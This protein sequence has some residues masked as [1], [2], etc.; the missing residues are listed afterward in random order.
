[1][2]QS[3]MLI[4]ALLKRDVRERT[5][6]IAQCAR[7]QARKRLEDNEDPE[8]AKKLA[9]NSR[10]NG[11][12]KENR[13][14]LKELAK[15]GDAEAVEKYQGLKEKENAR[16]KVSYKKKKMQSCDIDEV[17]SFSTSGL[18]VL[19]YAKRFTCSACGVA[20]SGQCNNVVGRLT[21]L[22]CTWIS[23]DSVDQK[24]VVEEAKELLESEVM[25]TEARGKSYCD[26]LRKTC[27]ENF[28]KLEQAFG[29]PPKRSEP[30]Q[31]PVV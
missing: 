26:L 19:S 11:Q 13:R 9:S 2:P 14:I 30:L 16:S 3:Q 23:I 12:R 4:A 27:E 31:T 5:N 25:E 22:G 8:T 1:M 18:P 21:C 15:C 24:E 28:Q 6:R 7:I 10:K 17:E 20:G 29:S